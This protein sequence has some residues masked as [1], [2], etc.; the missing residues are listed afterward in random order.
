MSLCF[1]LFCCV[2]EGQSIF[3][4]PSHIKE[5]NGTLHFHTVKHSDKGRYTCVARNA[6]GLIN[7]TIYVDV[8]GEFSK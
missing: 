5:V 7:A 6:E 2:Q 3:E 4:W 8:G 1:H